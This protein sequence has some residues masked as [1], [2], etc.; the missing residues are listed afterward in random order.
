MR[1]R[2][3]AGIKEKRTADC[4]PAPIGYRELLDAGDELVTKLH[5][6]TF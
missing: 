1:V 5:S 3:Q 6:H 2:V 4:K